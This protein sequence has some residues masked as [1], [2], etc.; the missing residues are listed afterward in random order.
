MRGMLGWTLAGVWGSFAVVGIVWA[1]PQKI[2]VRQLATNVAQSYGK[3]TLGRL[4]QGRKPSNVTVILENSLVEEGTPMKSQ[5]FAN[6]QAVE[7]WLQSRERE[8]GMPVRE[9]RSLKS[10]QK[11]VCTFDFSQGILHNHLYLKKVMYGYRGD[12][13]YIKTLHLLDGN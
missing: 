12:Q 9:S 10:C 5:E 4:D 8:P 13:P 3:K 7:T 1:A 11:G 6:F 2:T